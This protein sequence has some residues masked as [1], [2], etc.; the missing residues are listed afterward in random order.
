[1]RARGGAQV[2]H[3][4]SRGRATE[5]RSAVPLPARTRLHRLA[6]SLGSVRRRARE[7]T[8]EWIR[9]DITGAPAAGASLAVSRR[10]RVGFVAGGGGCGVREP[11]ERKVG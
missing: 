10:R 6:G 7:A 9:Q 8:A 4:S 1:M 3:Q 11:G 2:A 5:H